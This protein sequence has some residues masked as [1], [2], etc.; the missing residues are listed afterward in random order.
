[1][2]KS[3]PFI[4]HSLLTI[5]DPGWVAD[6]PQ[7]SF[8]NSYILGARYLNWEN[9][10]LIPFLSKSPPLGVQ[11]LTW[12][13]IVPSPPRVKKVQNMP[14]QLGLTEC[15][16]S[17]KILTKIKC[18]PKCNIGKNGHP[19]SV[20]NFFDTSCRRTIQGGK[21]IV[22][23][24]AYKHRHTHMHEHMCIVC[25]R[26]YLLTLFLCVCVF[27]CKTEYTCDGLCDVPVY[28]V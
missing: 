26:V 4:D 19:A 22:I 18:P 20:N 15:C 9:L 25:L 23:V 12:G 27:V 16:W 10:V 28:D 7:T 3:R 2:V 11:E 5:L 13:Q 14:G 8:S 17:Q 21:G 6:L 1:M 24:G